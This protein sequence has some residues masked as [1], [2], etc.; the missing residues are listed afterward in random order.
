MYMS[1]ILSVFELVLQQIHSYSF[2]C[3]HREKN[4]F[5]SRSSAKLTFVQL[6]QFIITLPRAS[7]QLELNKF[8][9]N[10]M[11]KV[12]MSKQALQQARM[13]LSFTAFVAINL[14]LA[15]NAYI[16][17]AYN[18]AFGFRLIA[19]DGSILSL[20]PGAHAGFGWTK[21]SENTLAAQARAMAF[22]DVCNDI[23]LASDLTETAIDERTLAADL[24]SQIVANGVSRPDD[25][26]LHDRGFASFDLFSHYESLGVKYLFRVQEHFMKAVNEAN[27][28]DQIIV[29]HGKNRASITVRILNVTLSTGA[30]E[31]LLT[32]VLDTTITPDNFKEIYNFRWGV[33][34]KYLELKERLDI[35]NFSGENENL[36]WQ[37]FYA[38]VFIANMVSLAKH[39]AQK[40]VDHD[41][42]NK[43]RK[44]NYKINTNI[45]IGTIRSMLINAIIAQSVCLRRL[46]FTNAVMM[47]SK[48][49]IPIRPGRS[50]PRGRK[51]PSTK[52]S[53]NLKSNR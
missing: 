17:G 16:D 41:N 28:P 15:K 38:T 42:S 34:I 1:D 6:I 24:A 18:T 31:K 36:I 40:L 53:L 30:N 47:I 39:E 9:E 8:L 29:L 44:Y 20:P 37:D 14:T 50:S 7:A 21:T 12:T 51:H 19:V 25:L 4:T 22:V 26:F 23:V 48:Y 52:F 10:L 33:E 46:L 35:E 32:N 3:E 2:L 49:V 27:E 43:K 13:K 11:T 5:F 45:A